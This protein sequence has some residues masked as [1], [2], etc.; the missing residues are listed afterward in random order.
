MASPRHFWAGMQELGVRLAVVM[1]R[2]AAAAIGMPEASF[3]PLQW[4]MFEGLAVCM[5]WDMPEIAAQEA[6]VDEVGRFLQ[7]TFRQLGV[8]PA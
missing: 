3:R 5:V 6:R 2:R 4:T 8:P 1:G 7:E